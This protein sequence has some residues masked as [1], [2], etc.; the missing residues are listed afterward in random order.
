MADTSGTSIPTDASGLPEGAAPITAQQS[1]AAT[2]HH[3]L[4]SR[5]STGTGAFN[6]IGHR[7][8]YYV[9]SASIV[10]LSILLIIIRGFNFS[11]DFVGGTQLT[12][13]PT[14]PVSNEQVAK[15]V[16]DA[17]GTQTD[18]V[19]TVGSNIQVGMP[20]LTADKVTDAKEALTD[21]FH[22]T[23]AV[24]DS[25]V[26]GTWGS[27]ISTRAL[28]AVLVF[29][30][31]VAAFIWL[32]YEH[33]VAIGAV[34]SV[35]HDLVVAAGVYALVGF[36]VA[37]ATVIGLLTILGFSL[38]DTVVVYDKVQ[39]NT[40]GLTS[41]LRRT[42]PEAANLA[43]N[44]TLMRS[45]N[46]SLI[47]LLPVAGLL[48]A[49]VALLGSGTLKDLS[50]VMLVGMLVGAYSSVFLAVPMA[51]D[52][53]MRDPVIKSHTH[54]VEAKRRSEGLIV[55]ADGDPVARVG[56]AADAAGDGGPV[57]HTLPGSQAAPASPLLKPGSGPLPGV[58]PVRPSG[59][60]GGSRSGAAPRGK[61]P[62][63]GGKAA[64]SGGKLTQPGGPRPAGK[65]S[66]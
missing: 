34:V 37:P 39:E 56:V 9:F 49:G 62:Q 4:L 33:R 6:I 63:P 40:K 3:S 57:R 41:L 13:H 11:L 55:D 29:L 58:K 2:R 22:L 42:Y 44:Q 12:F 43:I 64:Q 52:L 53:K 46:T 66:R 7:R 50:L 28:I 31:A 23:S 27:E 24:S 8:W 54:R 17:T 60:T 65:R 47:A 45:I 14:S 16:L 61:S 36:E 25:A 19:V 1:K 35:L 20:A 26:S 10:L 15:V 5:L 18:S 38:Y 21:A 30:V 51:V 59:K 48:V 32:R